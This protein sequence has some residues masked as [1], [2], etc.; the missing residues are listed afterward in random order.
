MMNMIPQNDNFITYDASQMLFGD[1][2]A[3]QSGGDTQ[4]PPLEVPDQHQTP[5][6]IPAKSIN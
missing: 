1:D 2:S 6:Q 3:P 5:E 4:N